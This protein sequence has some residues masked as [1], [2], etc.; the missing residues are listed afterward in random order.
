MNSKILFS[1]LLLN[2]EV[3]VTLFLA[4]HILK[5]PPGFRGSGA[6][7]WCPRTQWAAGTLSGVSW[8]SSGRCRPGKWP[9]TRTGAGGHRPALRQ[10][11]CLVSWTPWLRASGGRAGPPR[12]PPT[13]LPLIGRAFLGAKV[14]DVT[15]GAGA[16]GE[17]GHRCLAAGGRP[18]AALRLR[19]LLA[20]ASRRRP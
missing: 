7:R 10:S 3:G 12:A 19:R 4:L 11:G 17:S 5:A 16:P 13:A 18:G 14:Q 15:P 2:C 20:R 9:E 6:G 1:A 8:A